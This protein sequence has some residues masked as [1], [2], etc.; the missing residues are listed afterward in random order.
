MNNYLFGI[1][2]KAT[3]WDGVEVEGFVIDSYPSPKESRYFYFVIVDKQG[4]PHVCSRGKVT[5]DLKSLQ[6]RIN[7][8]DK[9]MINNRFELMDI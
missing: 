4:S 6:D 1:K 3:D 2:A 7:K 8:K 5:L 9:D